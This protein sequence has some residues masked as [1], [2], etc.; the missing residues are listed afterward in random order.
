[1]ATTEEQQ[2]IRDRDR[3][4]A[5]IRARVEWTEA[6]KNERIAA[7]NEWARNEVHAVREHEREQR[8]ARLERAKREVFRV[9]TGNMAT[10]AE[11]SQIYNGF[12]SAWAEVKAATSV[13]PDNAVGAAET[14]EE[15]LDQAERKGRSAPRPRCLPQEHRSRHPR[16]CG[17]VLGQQPQGSRGAGALHKGRRGDGPISGL[18]ALAGQR[19]D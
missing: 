16:R 15:I 3:E 5:N 18:R 17:S 10:G 2:I 8:D 9:P 6:A 19:L 1:M 12:R 14:L 7:V 4:I 11:V 13:S